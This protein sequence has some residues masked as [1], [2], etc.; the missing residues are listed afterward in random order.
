M[1]DV[2]VRSCFWKRNSLL[3]SVRY[4]NDI[5]EVYVICWN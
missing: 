3:V 2:D 4:Y 5:Y 1:V